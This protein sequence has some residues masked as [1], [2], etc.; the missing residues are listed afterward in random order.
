M[1]LIT[2][3]ELAG[4]KE[5]GH[6]YDFIADGS[7]RF[8][9]PSAYCKKKGYHSKTGKLCFS[10]SSMKYFS[11]N[12]CKTNWQTVDKYRLKN[13]MIDLNNSFNE[14]D[15]NGLPIFE[16][17]EKAQLVDLYQNGC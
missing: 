1:T 14:Y 11:L 9:L 4:L 12:Y 17:T 3:L 5:S 6:E 7:T 15:N 16:T 2:S 8:L 10:K 13:K